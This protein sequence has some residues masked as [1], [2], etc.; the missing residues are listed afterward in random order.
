MPPTNRL[1]TH[2][3]FIYNYHTSFSLS[4]DPVSVQRGKQMTDLCFLC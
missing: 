3:H 1:H 2:T 4:L